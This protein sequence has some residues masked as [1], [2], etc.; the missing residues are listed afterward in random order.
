MSKDAIIAKKCSDGTYKGIKLLSDGD[1]AGNTLATFYKEKTR[2]DKLINLG[3]LTL[4]TQNLPSIDKKGKY[5]VESHVTRPFA[6]SIDDFQLIGR[7]NSLKDI[8]KTCLLNPSVCYLYVYNY[9]DS[10]Q[11]HYIDVKAE[12]H[13]LFYNAMNFDDFYNNVLDV[14]TTTYDMYFLDKSDNE[15]YN[16]FVK[17]TGN[18]DAIFSIHD[19][20]K[21]DTGTQAESIVKID[22]KDSLKDEPLDANGNTLETLLK[23]KNESVETLLTPVTL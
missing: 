19:N 14:Y 4:L 23:A 5:I 22:N 7:F 12:N 18:S 9:D 20:R 15:V 8:F 13:R 1:F 2:V 16:W 10:R 3:C 11:W 17:E 6:K 21:F